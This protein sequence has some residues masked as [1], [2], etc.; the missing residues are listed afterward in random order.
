MKKTLIITLSLIADAVNLSLALL[1]RRYCVIWAVMV[2]SMLKK[3]NRLQHRIPRNL[4]TV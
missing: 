1:H 4:R 2:L 3:S